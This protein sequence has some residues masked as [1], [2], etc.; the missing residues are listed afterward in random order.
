MQ[1]ISLNNN[2]KNTNKLVDTQ[3]TLLT[4]PLLIFGARKFARKIKQINLIAIKE[5]IETWSEKM[6]ES[7]NLEE[8]MPKFQII[9]NRGS[10]S[11]ISRHS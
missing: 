9:Q 1:K 2:K 11:M 10:C 8:T 6:L 7:I 5:L 4:P 3:P